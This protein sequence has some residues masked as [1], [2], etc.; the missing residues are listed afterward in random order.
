MEHPLAATGVR[1]FGS[2]ALGTLA[3]AAAEFYEERRGKKEEDSW[4]EMLMRLFM[5]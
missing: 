3:G 2:A 4:L 1:S 5:D